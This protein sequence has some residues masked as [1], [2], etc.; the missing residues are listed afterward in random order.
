MSILQYVDYFRFAVERLIWR[1]NKSPIAAWQAEWL[2]TLLATFS[3]GI[4]YVFFFGK[5]SRYFLST[6]MTVAAVAIPALV[7]SYLLVRDQKRFRASC[8]EFRTWSAR[9]IRFADMLTIV[10]LVAFLG[11]AAFIIFL[12]DNLLLHRKT[13]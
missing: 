10:V 13:G 8:N 6:G 4:I 12:D 2:L 1:S 3:Y 7:T 11:V 5:S 9:K